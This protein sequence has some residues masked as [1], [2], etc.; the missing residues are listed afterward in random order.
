MMKKIT[1]NET[2]HGDWLPVSQ[3]QDAN[4]T[5]EI[6][7]DLEPDWIIVDHYALDVIWLSIVE[8]TNAKVLVIDDL[9]DR[10]LICDVLLDQNLGPMQRNT[11]ANCLLTASYF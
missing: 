10:E 8:K 9:G 1:Y 11:M 3:T 7:Y 2:A 6:I 4:E 5:A